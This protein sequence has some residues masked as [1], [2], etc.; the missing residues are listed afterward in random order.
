MKKL[1]LLLLLVCSP[2]FA[3]N[4]TRI[5]RACPSG[6]VCAYASGLNGYVLVGNG[7]DFDYVLASSFS[8]A[9][10]IGTTTLGSGTD[11]RVLFDDAGVIAENAGLTFTKG[12]G[13]L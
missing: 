12:T 3:A 13:T 2:V 11:K 5:V 1:L 8:S 7:V 9:I 10:T 4:H 6:T